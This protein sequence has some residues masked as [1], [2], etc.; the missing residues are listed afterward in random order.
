ML[1][2]KTNFGIQTKN[3]EQ[4]DLGP[5]CLLQRCFHNAL[6]DAIPTQILAVDL[7]LS[8]YWIDGY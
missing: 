4:S 3:V 6:L 1:M 2:S 8:N 7:Q 5:H